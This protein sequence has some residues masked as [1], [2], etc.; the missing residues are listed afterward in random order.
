MKDIT[1]EEA[2]KMLN[3]FITEHKLYNIKQ[4]DGLEHNIEKVLNELEKY[5]ELYISTLGRSLNNSI[6]QNDKH[7]NDLEELNEGWK[8][9][10]NKKDKIIDAMAEVIE[11][12]RQNNCLE[13]EDID[14]SQIAGVE[15]IKQYFEEEVKD[16]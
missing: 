6:K 2:V 12:C 11:E 16:E 5:K 8:I 15:A 14:L 3:K 1:T 9:E 4:S 10:L 7:N 13:S